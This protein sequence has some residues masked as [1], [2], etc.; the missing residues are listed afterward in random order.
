[1]KG[2]RRLEKLKNLNYLYQG[3][4][5]LSKI[6]TQIIEELSLEPLKLIHQLLTDKNVMMKQLKKCYQKVLKN[7]YLN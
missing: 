2:L 6:N 4:S 5:I 7:L 3:D 1:M